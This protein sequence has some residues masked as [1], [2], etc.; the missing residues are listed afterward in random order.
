MAVF[1]VQRVYEDVDQADGYRVLVDRMWSQKLTKEAAH[2]DEGDRDVAPAT[3]LGVASTE[4]RRLFGHD[5]A[6]MQEFSARYRQE[7]EASGAAAA[8]RLC[9]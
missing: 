8:I 1:R 3:N 5:P 9:V 7:L 6:R 2:I 4:L